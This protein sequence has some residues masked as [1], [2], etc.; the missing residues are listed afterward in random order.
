MALSQNHGEK[1]EPFAYPLRGPPATP[2][3]PHPTTA[4][5]GLQ[6]TQPAAR[7]PAAPKRGPEGPHSLGS[8]AGAARHSPRH[9]HSDELPAKQPTVVQNTG[10]LGEAPKGSLRVS[11]EE[12]WGKYSRRG[13]GQLLRPAMCGPDSLA[14]PWEGGPLACTALRGRAEA[15]SSPVA[16]R[17]KRSGDWIRTP[18]GL[19]PPG[20]GVINHL[21]SGPR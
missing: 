15:Q 2:H 4:T 17:E 7:Y 10:L 19:T 18:D 3:G 21:F 1:R 5:W 8:L 11:Q 13:F 6:G 16:C 20:I 12:P 14:L 9:K